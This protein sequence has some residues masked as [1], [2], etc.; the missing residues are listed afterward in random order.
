MDA[1]LR[2]DAAG[3]ACDTS[4]ASGHEQAVF[5][6]LDNNYVAICKTKQVKKAAAGSSATFVLEKW[7]KRIT[8]PEDLR[9]VVASL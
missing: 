4:P 9:E 3:R 2:L 7:K 1:K 8:S 5:A 6:V